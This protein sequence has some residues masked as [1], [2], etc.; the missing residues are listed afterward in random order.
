MTA[1]LVALMF[2]ASFAW[3]DAS[4]APLGEDRAVVD[5]AIARAV[6]EALG[7]WPTLHAV[8]VLAVARGVVV[9]GGT[10]SSQ[11]ARAK[12]ENVTRATAGVQDVDNR[13]QVKDRPI[14]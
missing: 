11:T 14:R 10:V 2:A 13:I 1:R 8:K 7:Q 6:Q 9:L 5:A 4:A 12:A 3:Q